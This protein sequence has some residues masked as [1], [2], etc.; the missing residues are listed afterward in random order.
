ATTLPMYVDSGG[1]LTRTPRPRRPP[2]SPYT[3]L[4]RSVHAPHSPR[5][6]V[7]LVRS[8]HRAVA[9]GHGHVV[10]VKKA[11]A[12]V[13]R[14]CHVVA[15]PGDA[16]LAADVEPQR[17]WEELL[18]RFV[19]GAGHG[20]LLRVAVADDALSLRCD[21]RS[22]D[23]PLHHGRK[24]APVVHPRGPDG[25]GGKDL[26]ERLL[27]VAVLSEGDADGSFRHR[28][29]ERRRH[30]PHLLVT[31]LTPGGSPGRAHR[32]RFSGKQKNTLRQESAASA[33]RA[34]QRRATSSAA[35]CPRRLTRLGTLLSYRTTLSQRPIGLIVSAP[36]PQTPSRI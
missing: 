29:A 14:H 17:L 15:S 7:P 4:F 8:R 31:P 18:N 33:G 12:D 16:D 21:H 6:V 10:Q 26:L 1:S 13:E 5:S 28:S 27:L 22:L 20:A 11:D 36:Q 24:L 9:H 19:G 2:L 34:Q 3:T 35:D 30:A 23:D 25:G 32:T